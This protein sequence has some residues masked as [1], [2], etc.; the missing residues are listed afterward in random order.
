MNGIPPAPGSPLEWWEHARLDILAGIGMADEAAHFRQHPDEWREFRKK[1]GERAERADEKR[2]KQCPA[3][4]TC[5]DHMPEEVQC[6]RERGHEPPHHCPHGFH[7]TDDARVPFRG[8][9]GHCKLDVTLRP[10]DGNEE[11][12]K[13]RKGVKRRRR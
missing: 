12:R 7:W 8:V 13:P 1:L 9:C 6:V 11:Q 5:V 10:E 2:A 4:E 3:R